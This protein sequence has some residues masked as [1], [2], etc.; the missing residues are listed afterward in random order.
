MIDSAITTDIATDGTGITVTNDGDGTIT[1][2]LA[3][4]DLDGDGGAT[5][6]PD[7]GASPAEPVPSKAT[8]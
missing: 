1:L 3:D 6:S 4:I 5:D 2:G 8:E 7:A